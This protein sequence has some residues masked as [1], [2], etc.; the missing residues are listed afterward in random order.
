MWV[1]KYFPNLLTFSCFQP[2]PLFL[3]CD[4]ISLLTD[5]TSSFKCGNLMKDEGLILQQLR[6]LTFISCVSV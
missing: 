1:K 2:I 4:R 5:E 6:D 3:G